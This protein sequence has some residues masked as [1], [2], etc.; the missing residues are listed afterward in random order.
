[1]QEEQIP[2]AQDMPL[3]PTPH[4]DVQHWKHQEWFCPASSFH[5]FPGRKIFKNHLGLQKENMLT[6]VKKLGQ[7]KKFPKEKQV[8]GLWCSQS[9]TARGTTELYW[10]CYTH[11]RTAALPTARWIKKE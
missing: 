2:I 6:L 7:Q 3:G 4:L 10:A 11:Q 8:T 9:P 1:M 5:S